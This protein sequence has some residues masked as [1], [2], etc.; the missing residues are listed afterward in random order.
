MGYRPSVYVF[1]CS[2]SIISEAHIRNHLAESAC[3]PCAYISKVLSIFVQMPTRV[4][5]ATKSGHLDSL[6]VKL[7]GLCLVLVHAA[8]VMAG[9]CSAHGD[10]A[11]VCLRLIVV[12]PFAHDVIESRQI[13]CAHHEHQTLM[14]FVSKLWRSRLSQLHSRASKGVQLVAYNATLGLVD[15]NQ[16]VRDSCIDPLVLVLWQTVPDHEYKAVIMPKG[17]TVGAA[18]RKLAHTVVSTM[19]QRH[20]QSFPKGDP[21]TLEYFMNVSEQQNLYTDLCFL[22]ALKFNGYDPT[23]STLEHSMTNWHGPADAKSVSTLQDG[24]R[25]SLGILALRLLWTQQAIETVRR[26]YPGP[27]W[28]DRCLFKRADRGSQRPHHCQTTTKELHWVRKDRMRSAPGFL[29]LAAGFVLGNQPVSPPEIQQQ[30]ASC[31]VVGNGPSVLW[32]E[33]GSWIDA[34][35]AVFRFNDATTAGYERH[36]GSRTTIRIVGADKYYTEDC[37]E[38]VFN[39]QPRDN[40][41]AFLAS[42]FPMEK[43]YA[44]PKDMRQA[45]LMKLEGDLVSPVPTNGFVG[46]CLALHLCNSVSTFGFSNSS[47]FNRL[48]AAEHLGFQGMTVP[49]EPWHY[50]NSTDSCNNHP[51]RT[52]VLGR[53]HLTTFKS[54]ILFR[55]TLALQHHICNY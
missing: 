44:V 26:I 48:E 42:A 43:L 52:C 37:A 18:V 50:D 31:A 24:I 36:V 54:E 21:R 53:R 16:P 15:L 12:A 35:E 51:E 8:S 2:Q 10:H 29:R 55:E 38:V 14:T 30:F 33:Q 27:F 7:I 20:I 6:P 9:T 19:R 34:H 22:Q 1:T 45:C 13:V 41:E 23:M 46:L 28:S 3:L 47:Q 39:R 11:A 4:S 49:G 32:R 25:P 17:N 40:T 5:T